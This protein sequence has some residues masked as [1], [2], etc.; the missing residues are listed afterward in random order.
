MS[1]KLENI[2]A[3][4]VFRGNFP[5]P[6]VQPGMMVTCTWYK[7]E[8]VLAAELSNT[9][10]NLLEDL[11]NK[12]RELENEYASASKVHNSTSY[13]PILIDARQRTRHPNF[14]ASDIRDTRQKIDELLSKKVDQNTRAFVTKVLFEKGQWQVYLDGFNGP[15]GLNSIHP[16]S[17]SN[18]VPSVING[19]TYNLE[20]KPLEAR[21]IEG[22]ILK[23]LW[24]KYYDK[25]YNWATSATDE[26]RKV[27]ATVLTQSSLVQSSIVYLRDAMSSEIYAI[28]ANDLPKHEHKIVTHSQQTKRDL[29]GGL[30]RNPATERTK[31]ANHNGAEIKEITFSSPVEIADYLGKNVRGQEYAVND[32]AVAVYDQLVRPLDVKKGNVLV[33]GPTGTGKTELARTVAELLSVPFAEAKLAGKSSTGYKG[34]NLATVFAD[35]YNFKDHPE[36]GKSVVF[37]DELDKLTEKHFSEGQGFG[38]PLQNELISWIESST[39]KVPLGVYGDFNVD[40]TH[41]LFIG[42]GAFVGLE[43]SIASRLGRNIQ[44]YSPADLRKVQEELYQQL[45]PDDL[46]KYG[47]KPELVGRFPNLTFTKPLDSEALIDIIKNSSKS[48]FKQQIRLLQEGYKVAVEV[49]EGAYRVVADAA[50]HLGT[51]ARGLETASQSLFKQ[52]K[53]NATKGTNIRI[54]PEMA[55]Q[56]LKMLLPENYRI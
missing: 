9:D 14:V 33:V 50:Q 28:S 4:L 34:D 52:I 16:L 55:Y 24:W 7:T 22:G 27:L 11:R 53:S 10:R 20:I 56:K 46:I 45:A 47:L 37:L 12:R 43:K 39:I 1:E 31:A 23:N 17:W 18:V 29:Q 15:V 25:F 30:T 32:V 35:L 19:D 38:G 44:N 6:H 49:D 13:N 3:E 5:E 48:T 41:M 54:T 2:V 21:I 36:L 51:G 26:P 42:A 8:K 40:T